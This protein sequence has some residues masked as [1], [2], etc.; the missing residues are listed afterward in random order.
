MTLEGCTVC[1]QF[2]AQS[3]GALSV[4]AL[5]VGPA[6]GGTLESPGFRC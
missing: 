4:G 3:D 6:M 1:V 5:S 2:A